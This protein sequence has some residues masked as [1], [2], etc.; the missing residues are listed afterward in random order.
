[1]APTD[2][3]SARSL[4]Q[5]DGG[6]FDAAVV[7]AAAATATAE[8]AAAAAATKIDARPVRVVGADALSRGLDGADKLLRGFDATLWIDATLPRGVAAALPSG[9]LARSG[10][11]TC[12]AIA[13]GLVAPLRRG[14]RGETT[15]EA[16]GEV[17]ALNDDRGLGAAAA[18]TARSWL[19]LRR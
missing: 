13:A 12:V 7:D 8:V 2:R 4:I 19:L 14:P 3:I 6:G 17:A 18:A 10:E 1:M 11:G 16:T 5:R 15:P 9:L